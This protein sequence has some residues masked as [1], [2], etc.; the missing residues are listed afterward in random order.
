ME[1]FGYVLGAFSNISDV[2]AIG[3][4]N[5]KADAKIGTKELHTDNAPLPHSGMSDVGVRDPNMMD[6]S[7]GP[8]ISGKPFGS[9][10]DAS[11]K[12]STIDK[13]YTTHMKIY[14]INLTKYYASVSKI[15]LMHHVKNYNLLGR[16]CAF[17]ASRALNSAGVFNIPLILP[18]AL[19]LQ[20][21]IRNYGYLSTL[22]QK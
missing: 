12:F 7:W 3:A 10:G 15:N 17:Q 9:L 13:W 8:E 16:N 11:H 4:G 6:I 22:I 18:Q 14:G 19:E 2:W 5:F 21:L 1:N 20:M